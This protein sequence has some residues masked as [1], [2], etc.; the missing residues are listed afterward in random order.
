MLI[1]TYILKST[2]SIHLFLDRNDLHKIPSNRLLT[3]LRIICHVASS[4]L[5]AVNVLL[6]ELPHGLGEPLMANPIYSKPT[7]VINPRH[8]ENPQNVQGLRNP[9]RR[10]VSS[11]IIILGLPGRLTKSRG[12]PMCSLDTLG[13]NSVSARCWLGISSVS[14]RCW[15]WKPIAIVWCA[16]TATDQSYSAGHVSIDTCLYS[17][18]AIQCLY[19]RA[20]PQSTCSESELFDEISE[21]IN[22]KFWFKLEI[23]IHMC[24]HQSSETRWEL[25]QYNY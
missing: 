6:Q 8:G 3:L 10:T 21:N 1:Q 17:S 13:V 4:A 9:F 18:Q 23:L 24:Q 14:T 5:N 25:K 2:L 12:K 7:L 19:S 16:Y 22:A 15:S 20:I 11:H